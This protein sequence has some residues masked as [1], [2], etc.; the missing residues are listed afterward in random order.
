MSFQLQLRVKK[1]ERSIERVLGLVGRRG[2]E[3]EKV[4]AQPSEGSRGIDVT[5]TIQ[6]DRSGEVLV[7]QIAKLYEVEQV[8]LT[9]RESDSLSLPNQREMK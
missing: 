9:D 7:R 5:L 8:E 6:S 3:I 4:L 1:A 2:Y